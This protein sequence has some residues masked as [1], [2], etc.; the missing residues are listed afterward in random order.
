[1]RETFRI[2]KTKHAATWFDGEGARLFGGRW[3]TQGTRLLYTSATLSLASLEMLVHL[4]EQALL[5]FYSFATVTF[6]EELILPVE[7]FRKLPPDWHAS[8]IPSKVQ[9][10][11]TAWAASHASTVLRVPTAIV[12]GEYNYLVNLDHPNAGKCKFGASR[13]FVF[14]ERLSR[15][16]KKR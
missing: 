16:E 13:P 14:D 3:N 15:I 2:F 7:E 6:P 1:M 9:E 5:Q 12:P 8:P 4:D 10:I 11:G